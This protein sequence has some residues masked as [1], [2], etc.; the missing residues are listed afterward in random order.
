MTVNEIASVT[1]PIAVHNLHGPDKNVGHRHASILALLNASKGGIGAFNEFNKKDLVFIRSQAKALGLTV[2]IVGL[3]G[4]VYDRSKFWVGK[5]RVKKIMQGG[6]VG[7][8]GTKAG[9]DNRRVGPNRYGIYFPVKVL[10]INFDF[11]FC[12]T[13]LMARAFTLHKWRQKLF[14]RSVASLGAGV[15][16]RDGIM[17]GDFNTNPPVNIPNLG[18]VN[19]PVPADMGRQHYT[20]M[21]RWGKHIYIAP[22]K[23]VNTPSDHDLLKST[24]TFYR[25][26]QAHLVPA[27]TSPTPTPKPHEVVTL[28]KPGNSRVK[29]KKYG[30]PVR[31]PWAKKYTRPSFKKRRPR[32]Y[33]KVA[34]WKTAYRRRL[35]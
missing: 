13:H 34:R 11:E 31:H 10:E 2:A 22:M 17:T 29:W 6:H 18:E 32:L 4:L 30:A 35:K 7:A 5:P 27:P 12:V 9:P 14:W 19:V 33:A 1:T 3:N 16:D 8:D 15:L 25:T 21:M 28:P 26:E 23:D 24:V 20:K